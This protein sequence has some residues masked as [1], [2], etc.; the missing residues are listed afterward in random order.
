MKAELIRADSFEAD[1]GRVYW[2]SEDHKRHWVPSPEVA[3]SYGW[4]LSTVIEYPLEKVQTYPLSFSVAK[5][6]ENVGLSR[7]LPQYLCGEIRRYVTWGRQWFGSQFRGHGLEISAASSPWPCNLNCTVDYMDPYGEE[8]GCKTG[9]QNKQ[10]VPLDFKASLEDMRN[11]SVTDYDFAMC[12]HVI[13]HTPRVMLALK[14]VYE[15]LAPGGMFVMAVPHKNYTFDCL[16]QVTPL[17]HHIEDYERYDRNRDVLHVVDFLENANEKQMGNAVDITQH[18]R[19]FLQGSNSLDLHYHTFTE[20]SFAE[21]M[22]WFSKH[23]YRWNSCE[24]FQRLEGSN[25]FFVRLIK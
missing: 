8:E 13:E 2:I 1:E 15:H 12:S 5:N 21:I 20:N 11:V 22:N 16:R 25:E 9:Y 23:I 3:V 4:D 14:N 7:K 17:E 24:I 18:C 6:F 19:E 10:F